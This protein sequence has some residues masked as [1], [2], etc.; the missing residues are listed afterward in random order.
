MRKTLYFIEKTFYFLLLLLVM[1]SCSKKDVTPDPKPTPPVYEPKPIGTVVANPSTIEYGQKATLT[2]NFINASKGVYIGGKKMVGQ[3]GTY[4]TDTAL[5][6][7]TSFTVIAQSKD[8]TAT[9]TPITVTV[10]PDPD[11]IFLSTAK[12]IR[13]QSQFRPVDS[14]M[15]A[16]G[17]ITDFGNLACDTNTFFYTNGDSLHPN[18]ERTFKGPCSLTPG[19]TETHQWYFLYLPVKGMYWH[20][21]SHDQFIR[22]PNTTD[23][24]KVHRTGALFWN[25]T[26]LNGSMWDFYKKVP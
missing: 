7:T 5:K 23:E 3:S 11:V 12:C 19:V 26:L 20:G 24:F 25:G 21:V 10:N 8:S 22:I 15:V 6:I 2:Y 4:T 1:A 18:I 17:I 16:W 14:P 13:T 9:F